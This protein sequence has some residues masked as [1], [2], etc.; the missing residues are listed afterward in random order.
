VFAQA[1]DVVDDMTTRSPLETGRRAFARHS[2][3]EAYEQLSTADRQEGTLDPEDLEKLATTAFLTGLDE[4]ST[5]V[6]TRAHQGF[7]QQGEVQRAVRAAFWLASG[8]LTRGEPARGGGW[9]KRA[10][11]LLDDEGLDCVEAGYL[12]LP[13][14]IRAVGAGEPE[15]AESA[16]DRAARIGERFGERDL[17]VVARHGRG[18]ALIRQG[19]LD[20]GLALLD[21]AMAA[22]EAGEVSPMIAGEVYCSVI[23]A[24]REIYDLKRA[25]AWTDALTDWCESQPDLVPYHGPCLV[26]RAELLQLHGS[27]SD[28]LSE[29]E[30][31]GEW[32]ARPPGRPAAADAFYRQAE[33]H[34]LRGEL[35]L[36]EA[37]YR[38]TARWSRKPRPGLA[39]L[40]QAQGRLDAAGATIRRVLEETHETADRSVVL[41][42]YVE[43]MLAAGDVDA[44]QAGAEDLEAIGEQIDA[45]MPRA[46]AEGAE[47]AVLLAR[48]EVRAGLERLRTAWARWEDLRAPYEAA[49][50][51]V[52]I[53]L[54]CRR[55]GDEDGAQVELDAARWTFE[56]LGATPDVER[57]SRLA[58]R[59]A[60][61]G[62]AHGLTGRELEVLRLVASGRTNRAIAERLSISERTVE[63]HVSNIFN[64][65]RVS[66]R[67]AATA[68][69]Y[70]HGLV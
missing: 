34:R 67:T 17:V 22:V 5:E 45:P 56:R 50:V 53:A 38:E 40:R 41:P 26:R 12:L 10:S 48:G 21:E 52:L 62:E 58:S 63:R 23:E 44:A 20:E 18:R 1:P 55:L 43:I 69:A 64:K 42:A 11:R 7:L 31:A 16:F 15:R 13:E 25:H 4:E 54:G 68:H 29:A 51:R 33:L 3:Q 65:L 39:L 36:A 66:S 70:E 24:C 8:L 46:L 61:G 6:W 19:R 57:V 60:S 32:L 37:A 2:W 30:R 9:L 49:R 14:G 35:D 27:W 47:G 28:A 59:A